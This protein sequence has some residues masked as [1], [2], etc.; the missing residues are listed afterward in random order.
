MKRFVALLLV[1]SMV[2]GLGA[3]A[4]PSTPTAT[5]TPSAT[6][7]PTSSPSPTQSTPTPSPSTLPA[8]V[9]TIGTAPEYP[10]MEYID[11]AGAMVG[12][13]IDL[14]NEL[15]KIAG[16]QM[17]WEKVA[18][19][20]IFASLKAN[21][22]DLIASAVTITNERANEMDFVGPYMQS[23]QGI[24]ILKTTT[25]IKGPEDLKGKKVGVQKGTTGDEAATAMEGLTVERYEDILL[26]FKDLE[27]GR[28]DAVVN[29][30]PVNAYQILRSNANLI[31]IAEKFTT[32][33]YGFAIRKGD[34]QLMLDFTFALQKA[35]FDGTYQRV[36][37]KWFGKAP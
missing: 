6:P 35:M 31:Q 11:D 25:S 5:P 17:K 30:V 9:V 33:D 22:V 32:E 28:I 24:V 15:G 29:D 2:I 21:K 4:Q 16:Y 8:K 27:N 26:A 23:G 3:C 19:D 12:F 34:D 37:E 10:P 13:D 1:L 36:Y 14:V 20:G 7:T 18:W